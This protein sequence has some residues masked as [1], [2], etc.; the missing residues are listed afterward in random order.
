MLRE[1][2]DYK[3]A[4]SSEHEILIL[5]YARWCGYCRAFKPEFSETGRKS[6]GSFGLI[7]ISSE[8]DPAWEDLEIDVV[9]TLLLFREGGIF[10]RKSGPMSQR[11][12]DSFM[13]KNNIR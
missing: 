9:P 1:F 5:F 12:L 11:D 3:E 4:E 13:R 7:D 8:D 6:K 2:D 10:D